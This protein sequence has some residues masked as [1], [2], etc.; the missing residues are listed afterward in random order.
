VVVVVPFRVVPGGGVFAVDGWV[1]GPLRVVVC[2]LAPPPSPER[3]S[4]TA[5]VT[6]TRNNTGAA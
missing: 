2:E 1:T 5:T 3:I 4:R 6:A